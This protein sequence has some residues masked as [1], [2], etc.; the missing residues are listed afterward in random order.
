MLDTPNDPSKV[1][2]FGAMVNIGGNASREAAAEAKIVGAPSWLLNFFFFGCLSSLILEPQN[3]FDAYSLSTLLLTTY[4]QKR[5]CSFSAH[6]QKA[7]QARPLG[8]SN[9]HRISINQ[10]Q[11]PQNSMPSER[12]KLYC[13]W[14]CPFAQRAWIALCHKVSLKSRLHIHVYTTGI[15]P[16]LNKLQVV[17]SSSSTVNNMA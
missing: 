10:V 2:T 12:T 16:I 1:M 4:T 3:I 11:K 13:A 17:E 7:F 6:T 14:F 8:I 5:K 15:V 9:R